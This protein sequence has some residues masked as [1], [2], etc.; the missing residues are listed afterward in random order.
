MNA[1][2]K[3]P[4]LETLLQSV[5]HVERFPGS[6]R[7]QKLR[8]LMEVYP[9]LPIEP[10]IVATV[11]APAETKIGL[12]AGPA[13]NPS[14]WCRRAKTALIKTGIDPRLDVWTAITGPRQQYPH[15]SRVP[16]LA[17]AGTDKTLVHMIT[18]MLLE[19]PVIELLTGYAP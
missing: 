19:A 14:E 2:F 7:Y 15:G 6:A 17:P 4:T 3:V 8:R 13:P 16:V 1:E 10:K 18:S 9:I 11:P 12:P 5:Q